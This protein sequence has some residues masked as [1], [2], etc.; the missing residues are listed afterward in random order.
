MF[1]T[2]LWNSPLH[3]GSHTDQKILNDER[4]RDMFVE[5]RV[6]VAADSGFTLNLAGQRGKKQEPIIGVTP[7]SLAGANISTAERE[8]RKEHNKAL[9]SQRVIVENVFGRLKKWGI[10][11]SFC[12]HYRARLVNN[13]RRK[14]Y[15]NMDLIAEILCCIHNRDLKYRPLRKVS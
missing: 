5:K 10:M 13:P 2:V 8:R 7:L 15:F 14:N 11:G 1:G 12:R 6:G 9:S 3:P 4:V